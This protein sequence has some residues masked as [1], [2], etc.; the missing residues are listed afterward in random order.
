MYNGTFFPPHWISNANASARRGL[1]KRVFCCAAHIL[2]KMP[3]KSV[4]RC[5]LFKISHSSV[6][7]LLN[8]S[9][10]PKTM[11]FAENSSYSES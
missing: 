4:F 3:G 7:S 9:S 6:Q 2:K 1:G 5:S 11:Y 8:W 10:G